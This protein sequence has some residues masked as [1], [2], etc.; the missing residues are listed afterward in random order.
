MVG[1]LL[2]TEFAVNP[3]SNVTVVIPDMSGVSTAELS[4][5]AA[6]LSRVADVSA[7]SSTLGQFRGGRPGGSTVGSDRCRGRQRVP[8]RAEHRPAV[9]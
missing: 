8:H 9:F 1:D 6:H 4:D 3:A 7:V 5:Y 2:R